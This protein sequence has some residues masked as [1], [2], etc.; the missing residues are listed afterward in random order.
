MN[1]KRLH[2]EDLPHSLVGIL[3]R[4][5]DETSVDLKDDL[6]NW[7]RNGEGRSHSRSKSSICID[8]HLADEILWYVVAEHSDDHYK[9]IHMLVGDFHANVQSFFQGD[10]SEMKLLTSAIGLEYLDS[11]RALL[12]L[13]ATTACPARGDQISF[14]GCSLTEAV[15]NE[16]IDMLKLLAKNNISLQGD[17]GDS[18]FGD[19][20]LF[21]AIREGDTAIVDVLMFAGANANATC[22]R[23]QMSALHV[24][25]QSI[26]DD[27]STIVE[28]LLE[29]G[30]DP[31]KR[32]NFPF[33]EFTEEYME[34]GN[35]FTPLQ[36]LLDPDNGP[37]FLKEYTRIT[38]YATNIIDG[39]RVLLE[40]R[41]RE[42]VAE[43]RMA[44][45]MSTHPRLGGNPG[46]RIADVAG[47]EDIIRMVMENVNGQHHDP[48]MRHV[49][50]LPFPRFG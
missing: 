15:L 19:P 1:T 29:N 21:T 39:S 44:L 43:W 49:P 11:V 5:R 3:R 23:S 28:T 40:N 48:A 25:V 50:A 4:N 12:E 42:Q 20:V 41:M 27:A 31:Q 34:R 32:C 24:A 33:P 46:C 14:L 8:Q 2:R 6:E 18:Y 7:F 13:G 35:G 16:R 30:A 37:D 26:E 22:S 17:V 36:L 9:K 38:E 45:Y 10:P 47:E